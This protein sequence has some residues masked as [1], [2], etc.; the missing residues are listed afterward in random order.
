MTNME[1]IC[2]VLNTIALIIPLGDAVYFLAYQRTHKLYYLTGFVHFAAIFG[3]VVC[4]PLFNT[5]TELR[6]LHRIMVY[7]ATVGII[8]YFLEILKL[9]NAVS[10]KLS[11][12]HLIRIQIIFIFVTALLYLT[13]QV[14]TIYS[15]FPTVAAD[16]PDYVNFVHLLRAY[17]FIQCI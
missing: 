11:I 8:S 4:Y 10:D 13:V 1:M 17:M 3:A 12:K 5:S 9:F 2:Y 14:F 6:V 15:L 16:N 7:F